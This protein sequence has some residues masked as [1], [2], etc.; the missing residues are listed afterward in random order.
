MA[1]KDSEGEN[2]F[3]FVVLGSRGETEEFSCVASIS[4][5][6]Y[7]GCELESGKDVGVYFGLKIRNSGGNSWTIVSVQISIDGVHQVDITKETE[8]EGGKMVTVFV[9]DVKKV[10]GKIIK[11][12]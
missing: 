6:F 10:R 1:V 5:G 7:R 3:S 8:I 12:G 9:P 2:N 11:I 4:R